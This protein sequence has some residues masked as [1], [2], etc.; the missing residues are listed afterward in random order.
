MALIK[1]LDENLIRKLH[2][3]YISNPATSL[4][5]IGA[6]LNVDNKT[7]AR[8][9]RA[10]GL[11]VKPKGTQVG[12][13]RFNPETVSLTCQNCNKL[14]I[15]LDSIY[16]SRTKNKKIKFCSWNCYIEYL[17]KNSKQTRMICENCGKEFVRLPR[18]QYKL[19][20]CSQKC[21]QEGRLLE[22]SKWRD[23]NYIAQYNKVYNEENKNM[24]LITKAK[25]L[26]RNND[27]VRAIK[28]KYRVA[29]REKINNWNIKRQRII[30]STDFTWQDWAEIKEKY[31][32]T[33][34]KCGRRE[35]E[36]KLTIDHIIP[37]KHGGTNTKD[38]IQP[39]CT[40]CNS[41]K[42]TKTE[43]YRK[44]LYPQYDR[45]ILKRRDV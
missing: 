37:L 18:K 3:K 26:K 43:D 15:L 2:D 23:K 30:R 19:T 34:L 33:C 11:E 10:L 14:F 36:I 41:S 27:K 40:S 1:K 29:N 44:E 35:P 32:Y 25:W 6:I 16:R 12:E 42:G 9:F 45:R 39:L 13:N 17:R 24:I 8:N 38:N 31:D 7:V 20:Y 22:Y 5:D 4:K 28:Q 21:A